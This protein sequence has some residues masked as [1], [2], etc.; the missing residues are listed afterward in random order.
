MGNDSI[1]RAA[2]EYLAE[3][4]TEEGLTAE[5]KLNRDAANA[6]GPAVWKHLVETVTAMCK[7]W[8]FV[9]KDPTL[10]CNETVLGDLRIRCSGRAPHQIIIHYEPKRRLVRIENTAREDH[11]PKVVLMIEGYA[12]GSGRNAH[13]VRN[14]EP[15]NLENLMLGQI[16]VL[17]GLRRKG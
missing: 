8:N 15:V 5:E 6:Y 16:R 3:R 2:Q 11:E 12:I 4:L 7:E 13:L 17:A 14:H 1:R 10:T 9:T